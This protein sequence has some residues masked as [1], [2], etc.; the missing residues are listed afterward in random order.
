MQHKRPPIPVIVVIIMI[1][2]TLGFFGIRALFNKGDSTLTASGTIE[3]VEITISPEFSGKVTEVLVDEGTPVKAGDVLFRLDDTM[4]QAQR[5]VSAANRELTLDAA[6]TADTALKTAQAQYDLV[7]NASRLESI[8]TRTADWR[9]PNLAGYTLPGGYF[10]RTEQISASQSEVQAA[11]SASEAAQIRLDGMLGDS[12]NKDFSAAEKR[13]AIARAAFLVA[14]EIISHTG[15]IDNSDLR[16]TAQSAYDAARTELEDAQSNYDNQKDTEATKNIIISRAELSAALERYEVAQD[17]LLA[18]QTGEYSPRVTAAKAAVHQAEA[19]FNQ[20]MLAVTQGEASLSLIDVQ[21]G[22]LMVKAPV[23]GVI[24][25][26]N[27]EP[28]EFVA[29]GAAAMTLGQL[30]SLT[31]TVYIPENRYGELSIGQ[32]STVTVDSFPDE[33]FNATVIHI[34][35]Q[36]EFIPR[37]VQT[38]EGRTSTV[39]AIKLQVQ[40]PNGK[41]K[42]GM[43]ADVLFVSGK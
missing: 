2:L 4:L 17:H 8:A 43:P 29:P 30:T 1:I 41:L 12:T 42:P 35:D 14:Q 40:D 6:T 32:S 15:T 23:D 26:R 20:T 16:D 13:L 38:V 5:R 9:A 31:I 33:T 10:N 37:N 21:I 19:A 28:G 34:A 11:K 27:I 7:L 36:A 3:A 39:F 24:M 18:L 22:K 25:T